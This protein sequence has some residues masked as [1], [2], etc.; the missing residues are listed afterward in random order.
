MGGGGVSTALFHTQALN[1]PR[2]C[3]EY[4]S[5]TPGVLQFIAAPFLWS[6]VAGPHAAM[7]RCTPGSF[8]E[9]SSLEDGLEKG[10]FA[11]V[12]K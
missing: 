2:T 1:S 5:I 7:N 9:A 12:R 10:I 3:L 8:S 11:A 4:S 6:R